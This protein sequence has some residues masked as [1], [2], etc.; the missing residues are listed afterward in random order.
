MGPSFLAGKGDHEPKAT[1][2]TRRGPGPAGGFE[3]FF[4]FFFSLFL[5]FLLIH[6]PTT[7]KLASSVSSTYL[8]LLAL[9]AAGRLT[10]P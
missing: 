10:L 9:F 1:R 5:P 7:S 2:G 4:K 3:S 6:P 8:T